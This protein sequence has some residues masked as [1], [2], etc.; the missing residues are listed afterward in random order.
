MEEKLARF[1]TLKWSNAREKECFKLAT[2]CK[3]GYLEHI[4][5]AHLL[6]GRSEISRIRDK[7]FVKEQT[8]RKQESGHGSDFNFRRSQFPTARTMNARSSEIDLFPRPLSR[9][10][11]ATWP[12]PKAK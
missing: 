2:K 6:P 12:F 11:I 3:K 1:I 5:R 4:S 8:L 10:R 9:F 7:S